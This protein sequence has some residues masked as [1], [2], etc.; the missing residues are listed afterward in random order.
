MSQNIV[1]HIDLHMI[2]KQVDSPLTVSLNQG[3][4]VSRATLHVQ[5][6]TRVSFAYPMLPIF[7]ILFFIVILKKLFTR[8]FLMYIIYIIL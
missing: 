5:S 7:F 3:L 8:L 6:K 4:L 1:L 2:M